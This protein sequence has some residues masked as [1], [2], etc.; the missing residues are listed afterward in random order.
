MSPFS[1]QCDNRR[2]IIEVTNDFF[3]TCDP[4]SPSNKELQH[5]YWKITELSG[6]TIL[7]RGW[8]QILNVNHFIC[9]TW[10]LTRPMNWGLK[11]C[12]L[13]L[14]GHGLLC[15]F[16][17]AAENPIISNNPIT[18]PLDSAAQIQ[19]WIC[20]LARFTNRLLKRKQQCRISWPPALF[21]DLESEGDMIIERW[22][23]NRVREGG[24]KGRTVSG[25]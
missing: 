2:H 18:F 6:S 25:Q 3:F 1:F 20:G 13:A 23:N 22:D 12:R 14:L 11:G 8:K 9:A 5:T 10:A 19:G 4:F 21:R 15:F 7:N 17:Q 16:G 24:K